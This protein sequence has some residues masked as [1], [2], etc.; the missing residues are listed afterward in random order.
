M[1][2]CLKCTE[3]LAVKSP[4]RCRA[5]GGV[6][7]TLCPFLLPL[8]FCTEGHKS[9]T[10]NG[11]DLEKLHLN[12]PNFYILKCCCLIR[13][14]GGFAILQSEEGSRLC[15]SLI[16]WISFSNFHRFQSK[17]VFLHFKG[18]SYFPSLV[19]NIHSQLGVHLLAFFLYLLKK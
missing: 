17:S 2:C 14:G 4:L 1:D 10:H 16:V 6:W 13:V 8:C 5:S 12:A 18:T 7:V 15:N 11:H 9:T 3:I 19:S